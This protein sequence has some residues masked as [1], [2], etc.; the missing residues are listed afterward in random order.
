MKPIGT[1]DRLL[2]RAHVH[3]V[4]GTKVRSVIHDADRDGVAAVVEQQFHYARRIAAAGLVPILEPEVSITSPHKDEAES[5][6]R[7]HLERH[8]AALPR[9]ASILLTLTISTRLG[10]YSGLAADPR[11]LRVL[12]LSGTTAATRHARCSPE[13]RA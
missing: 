10:Q 4:V 8:V 5:L 12:A 3:R 13:S 11:V 1:L 2:E 7:S 9:D 6:L